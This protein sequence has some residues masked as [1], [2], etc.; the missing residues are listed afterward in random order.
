VGT[1]C[2]PERLAHEIANRTCGGRLCGHVRCDELLRLARQIRNG[3]FESI[4]GPHESGSLTVAEL[5]AAARRVYGDDACVVVDG[6]LCRV[7]DRE[8]MKHT[9]YDVLR[10]PLSIALETLAKIEEAS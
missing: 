9:D 2:V 7:F 1:L 5:N 6:E 3:E 8:T 4:L 10:V